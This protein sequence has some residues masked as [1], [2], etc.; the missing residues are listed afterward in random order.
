MPDTNSDIYPNQH[1]L[2]LLATCFSFS[3]NYQ[4]PSFACSFL[5]RIL[6]SFI[7]ITFY[8]NSNFHFYYYYFISLFLFQTL[9]GVGYFN[10]GSSIFLFL[11][12]YTYNGCWRPIYFV[13]LIYLDY[14]QCFSF[15]QSNFIKHLV[16]HIFPMLFTFFS[17]PVCSSRWILELFL[18]SPKV[19]STDF[20]LEQC[21]LNNALQ[22][23]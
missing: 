15:Y 10:F 14:C 9:F 17:L 5:K 13:I 16:P 8:I 18:P 4:R 6:W 2:Y 7:M 1:T 3:L 19:N 22:E 23:D 11:G 20:L 21:W 12:S